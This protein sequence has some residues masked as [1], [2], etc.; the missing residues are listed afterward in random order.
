MHRAETAEEEKRRAHM[1]RERD[2]DATTSFP[3]LRQRGGQLLLSSLPLSP[4]LSEI[5]K[6]KESTRVILSRK[7][8]STR[9]PTL[10]KRVRRVYRETA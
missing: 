10:R 2:R 4:S 1:E 8:E 7:R 5:Y 6:N 3:R 9:L